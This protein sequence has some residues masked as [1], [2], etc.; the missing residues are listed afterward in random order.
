[1]GKELEKMDIGITESLCR[2]PDTAM[3]AKSP[4]STGFSR[5]EYN[6]LPLPPPHLKLTHYKSKVVHYKI[7]IVKIRMVN[8]FH[9]LLKEVQP[10]PSPAFTFHNLL[11]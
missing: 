5:Q 11:Q 10:P 9:D 4:Q 8:P 1:M 7:K 6:G 2:T 3:A